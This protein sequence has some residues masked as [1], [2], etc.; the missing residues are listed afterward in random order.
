MRR[1]GSGT[2]EMPVL[3]GPGARRLGHCRL[4]WGRGDGAAG[5]RR[6]K[7]QTC[8]RGL[9]AAETTSNSSRKAAGAIFEIQPSCK[10]LPTQESAPRSTSPSAP[11]Q[12]AMV[13]WLV[14]SAHLASLCQR[15][16]GPC[17]NQAVPSLHRGAPP[18]GSCLTHDK[19]KANPG[20]H[21]PAWSGLSALDV[22]HASTSGHAL[23]QGW[24]PAVL[25]IR[26]SFSH[27]GGGGCAFSPPSGAAT[28]VIS[29]LPLCDRCPHCSHAALSWVLP[30]SLAFLPPWDPGPL[31]QTG[32][33]RPTSW[34][35]HPG[36]S[37]S[38]GVGRTCDHL[39]L[40]K[41]PRVLGPRS[42]LIDRRETALLHTQPRVLL[43][44]ALDN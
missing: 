41:V 24:A 6:L 18:R 15:S 44:F 27:G 29:F 17:K 21:Q 4:W 37:P 36:V 34:C 43:L 42:R 35:S 20:A 33:S 30:P 1:L 2:S 16:E 40:Q 32:L 3:T 10:S 19:C 12:P 5:G 9:T 11:G 22:I 26:G 38:P 28:V 23:Q 14:N 39:C 7:P 8:C 25:N 13:S 31:W